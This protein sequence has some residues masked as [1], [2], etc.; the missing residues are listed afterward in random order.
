MYI[1]E[2][3]TKGIKFVHFTGF[4]HSIS[5]AV[6]DDSWRTWKQN[7]REIEANELFSCLLPRLLVVFTQ[8]LEI[9]VTTLNIIY[10]CNLELLSHD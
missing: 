5:F 4:K 7:G 2:L 1:N 8:Q 10:T 3:E 9:L 6:I